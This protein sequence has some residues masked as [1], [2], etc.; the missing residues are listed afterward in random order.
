MTE[1]YKDML[2][3]GMQYQ[4]FVSDQLRKGEPCIFIGAY[5]S[6]KY[7]FEH[8]ESASGIEIKFD[9]KM[10]STGN[11]YIEV[12]EKSNP[13]IEEY[14][15][16]GIMRDDK[17]WL[18]LI[19]DYERAFLF[20]KNQLKNIYLDKPNYKKRGIREV[21]TATSIGILY[22]IESA[23]KAMCLHQFVWKEGKA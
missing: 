11:L 4:D 12:A 13:D 2:E 20:S 8:G 15:N 23:M 5:S 18:Y 17:T 1:Y 10:K 21:K 22:P 3:A 19:G 9:D 14:T 16:S 7:Q 6:R